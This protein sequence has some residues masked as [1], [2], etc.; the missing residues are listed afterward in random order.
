MRCKDVPVARAAV[1]A[2]TDLAFAALSGDRSALDQVLLKGRS[3]PGL[4]VGVLEPSV[5]FVAV[6]EDVLDR[7][8]H[9]RAPG[10]R[11]RYAE[12]RHLASP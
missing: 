10:T 4:G 2:S 8:P 5:E 3:S 9:L 12:S 1:T 6:V 7:S 11:L